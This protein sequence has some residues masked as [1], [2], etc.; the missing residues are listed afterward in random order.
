LKSRKPKKESIDPELRRIPQRYRKM[1]DE[2]K[3]RA[4]KKI[5][6]WKGDVD[7]ALAFAREINPQPTLAQVTYGAALALDKSLSDI[8]DQELAKA[9]WKFDPEIVTHDKEWERCAPFQPIQFQRILDGIQGV[10][11]QRSR[12]QHQHDKF[13]HE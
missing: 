8:S 10:R 12:G 11:K 4:A 3:E 6:S 2:E 9:L 13:N 7:A 5:M 1:T